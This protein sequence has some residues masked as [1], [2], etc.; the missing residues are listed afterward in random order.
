MKKLTLFSV[1]VVLGATT[2]IFRP[3]SAQK[4]TLLPLSANVLDVTVS[5]HSFGLTEPVAQFKER[6]TRLRF[7][8]YLTLNRPIGFHTGVDVEYADT[9]ADVPVE[10]VADGTVIISRWASGYGGVIV[11]QNTRSDIPRFA[12]YGHLNPASLVAMGIHV[13][14]GQQLGILGHDHSK[15]TG[16]ARK[17]LHFA[18]YTGETMNILGYVP[19]SAALINW[20]DPLRF[21]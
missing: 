6:I 9:L 19:D 10:A 16:G 2:F 4:P 20:A 3:V 1:A 17:H 8:Q 7:G 5:S 12:L 13:T 21:F 15:E 14:A 11:V 18:F